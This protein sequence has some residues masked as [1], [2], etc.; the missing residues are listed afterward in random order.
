M[1]YVVGEQD[2]DVEGPGRGGH[3]LAGQRGGDLVVEVQD[4]ED[5]EDGDAVEGEEEDDGE[6]E[7][8]GCALG[9]PLVGFF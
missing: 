8:E 3:V 5:L 4:G 7:V 2:A 1:E 6:A 9:E